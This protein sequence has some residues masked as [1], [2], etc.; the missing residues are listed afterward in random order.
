MLLPS[1]IMDISQLHRKTYTTV[2][3]N[4]LNSCNKLLQNCEHTEG[5][6]KNKVIGL[7]QNNCCVLLQHS[8]SR[9][10]TSTSPA[11]I[12]HSTL[13]CLHLKSNFHHSL[14]LFSAS[15]FLPSFLT[16]SSQTFVSV[17]F[18]WV[19]KQ[20]KNVQKEVHNMLL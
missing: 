10:F 4:C 18:I 19:N 3:N 20:N 13:P 5:T 8:H 2:S 12:S 16:P 17:T 9:D 14:C 7:F 6:A 1:Y 15:P 11:P